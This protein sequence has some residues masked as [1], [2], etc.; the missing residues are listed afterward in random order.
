[1]ADHE[2][3]QRRSPRDAHFHSMHTFGDS[4]SITSNYNN[5]DYNARIKA[6]ITDLESQERFNYTAT[7]RPRDGPGWVGFCAAHNPTQPSDAHSRFH[8]PD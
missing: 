7:A 5:M 6:A 3:A 2:L 8:P 4:H 1:M